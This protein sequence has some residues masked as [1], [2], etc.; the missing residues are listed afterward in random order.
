MNSLNDILKYKVSYQENTW[1][2]LSKDITIGESLELIKSNTYKS[3]IERLRNHLKNGN[4]A[5]YDKHK[6]TLPAVTFCAT[7]EKK[8]RKEYLNTYNSIIVIDI[9]KL[10]DKELKQVWNFLEKDPLIFTFWKSP[11]NKGIKGLI[12]IKYDFEF[13]KEDID[14]IHKSAFKK[15]AIYFDEKYGIELDNSGSDITRL[16][17]FSYDNELI[18][19]ND[20]KSFEILKSDLLV[21]KTEQKGK[22]TK[23]KSVS[24]KDALY[25]PS[26]RNNQRDR[27]TIS[28]ILKFL[29]H[30]NL[31]ITNS[32][33]NW[34]KVAMSIT[35]SFT[36]DIGLNYFKRFSAIDKEK[37][38]EINCTNFLQNCYESRNGSINFNYIIHL[39]NEKDY[40]TK[41]QIKKGSEAEG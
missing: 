31:S 25:N 28:S 10:E 26:N 11:S 6:V 22:T 1:T 7:F 39:A 14:L 5:E 21:I 34:Y 37:Y 9:D 33:E 41:Q 23:I 20:Y 38:N 13:N 32:Y 30:K 27:K 15:S 24:N 40:F 29:E 16:C 19:K 35:N 3:R 8:R 36:Y 12:S 18:L 2:S 4:K 17:F